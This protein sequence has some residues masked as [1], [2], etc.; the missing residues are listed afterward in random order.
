MTDTE[1]CL[2]HSIIFPTAS[3]S[4]QQL[5]GS[6]CIAIWSCHCPALNLLCIPHR[7][8]K[9]PSAKCT[10]LFRVSFLTT[11]PSYLLSAGTE[12][13][14]SFLS[15]FLFCL[16]VFAHVVFLPSIHHSLLHQIPDACPS[17]FSLGVHFLE[18]FTKPQADYRVFIL[19]FTEFYRIAISCS[20]PLGVSSLRAVWVN[21]RSLWPQG[22]HAWHTVG[23]YHMFAEYENDPKLEQMTG[24]L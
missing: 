1:F 22:F 10:M 2:Y 4:S 9:N 13:F 24:V 6:L 23:V 5:E 15:Y 7:H 14:F 3:L 19:S 11:F 8:Q 21:L 20:S 18:A 12:V 16:H 17:R